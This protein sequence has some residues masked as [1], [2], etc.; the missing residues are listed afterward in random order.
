MFLLRRLFL[1]CISSLSWWLQAIL[2]EAHSKTI[3]SCEWSPNGRYLA[4]ASFDGTA[5]VWECAGGEFECLATLEVP[6]RHTQAQTFCVTRGCCFSR[7]FNEECNLLCN[8]GMSCG[9]NMVVLLLLCWF[10]CCVCFERLFSSYATEL[11][12][13]AILAQHHEWS[14]SLMLGAQGHE[15][16]V[17]SVAWNAD[18]TLL[19]TCS[20]DKSVWVWEVPTGG[21]IGGD[22]GISDFECIA[23][24]QGHTQDVKMVRWH[25]HQNWLVSASYDDSLKVNPFHSSGDLQSTRFRMEILHHQSSFRGASEILITR[26]RVLCLLLA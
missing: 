15:S 8:S 13:V 19:A 17:K 3:R 9:P 6:V 4:T 7:R 10:F 1:L 5:A 24:L 21:G 26:P 18:S 2:E 22:P 23:V 20:R 25:P 11:S 12:V 16:E 14:P